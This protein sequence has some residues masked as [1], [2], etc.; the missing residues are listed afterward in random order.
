MVL[1]GVAY[2]ESVAILELLEERFPSPAL[3]PTD[4]HG[5]A[6]VRALVEIVNSGIQPLQNRNVTLFVSK[7]PDVQ[8]EWLR[9]FIARGLASLE[10]AMQSHADEGVD[11]PYAYGALP[12][13]ADVLLVP[14]IVS[15]QRFKID[16]TPYARVTRAFEAAS[17]LPVF[18][19]AAPDRQPDAVLP[20]KGV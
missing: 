17:R 16:L 5:R 2:V 19:R 7:D 3:L 14:Q 8:K 10:A 15:A 13:L 12:T 4:A 6:R 9:H 11:G 1:D 18:E 20:L